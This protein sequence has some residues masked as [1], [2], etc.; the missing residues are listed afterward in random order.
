[1]TC[2]E[3]M[4]EKRFEEVGKLKK[5]HYIV[6][7]GEANRIVSIEKSKPGKHGSAKA[8]ITAIGVFTGKKRS[9]VSP[10]N[11]N[12]EIPIIEKK[13]CQVIAVTK[14]TVQLMDLQTYETFEVDKPED[15]S[16]KLEA[17]SEVEVWQSLG[18]RK[19][20]KVK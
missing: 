17:G 13:T 11:A 16:E 18:Y 7:E 3:E 10:V 20:M 6:L 15:L 5:G 9:L 1:M 2:V 4:S 14:E 8:R 19:I 12:I